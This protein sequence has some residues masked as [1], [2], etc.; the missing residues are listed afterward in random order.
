M[1]K[2]YRATE[3]SDRIQPLAFH[4]S[5]IPAEAIPGIPPNTLETLLLRGDIKSFLVGRGR[6][7]SHSELERFVRKAEREGFVS[8]NSMSVP[9][10]VREGGAVNAHIGT[11]AALRAKEARQK[12]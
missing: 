8:V 4:V 11:A 3:A 6:Y 12:K 7:V 10:S 2:K 5:N 9:K 1:T